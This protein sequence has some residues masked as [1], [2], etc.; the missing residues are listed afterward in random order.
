M[1]ASGT[2]ISFSGKYDMFDLTGN[3][4]SGRMEMTMRLQIDDKTAD[5]MM[6]NAEKGRND[7]A[8]E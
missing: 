4:I 7:N 1:K 3:P 5:K 8:S 6:S 2:L